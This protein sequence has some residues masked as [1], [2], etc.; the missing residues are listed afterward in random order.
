ME[1]ILARLRA[2]FPAATSDGCDT[3]PAEG[4][5]PPP[6]FEPPRGIRTG[7]EDPY[8]EMRRVLAITMLLG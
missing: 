6:P 2:L 8:A 7:Y 4:R 5:D 1:M 3:A